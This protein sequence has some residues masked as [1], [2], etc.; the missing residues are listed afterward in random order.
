MDRTQELSD[1]I[2]QMVPHEPIMD[3]LAITG[4]KVLKNQAE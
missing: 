1:L 4:Q 2:N 3:E